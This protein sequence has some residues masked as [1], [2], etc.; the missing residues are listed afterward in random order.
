MPITVN[1]VDAKNEEIFNKV[2]DYFTKVDE[3]FSTYKTTSEVSLINRGEL[4]FEQYS[5]DMK[6]I[7]FLADKTKYETN[8][9]FDIVQDGKMD[10]SGLVKGWAILKVAE[11]IKKEGFKNFY[12]DAGGDVEVSGKNTEGQMWK[13]GIRNPLN[14]REIIKTIQLSNT[15]VATSGVYERGK[16]IYNPLNNSFETDLASMTVIGPDVFEADRFATA[17]FAMGRGGIE[18]IEKQK[19]LEGY[20]IDR[21]G[22]ATYTSGFEK[23]VV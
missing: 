21:N 6:E 20:M 4:E 1:I 2:F 15:G 23:Y 13:V 9:Y 17:A 14:P 22:L 16:H 7:L 8:N 11:M 3:K 10:P 5:P 12:V 19:D 18:F